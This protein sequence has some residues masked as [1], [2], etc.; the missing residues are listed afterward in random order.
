MGEMR[1][2]YKDLVGKPEAER[3]FGKPEHRWKDNIELT[4]LRS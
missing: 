3:L 1:N 4:P 2:T